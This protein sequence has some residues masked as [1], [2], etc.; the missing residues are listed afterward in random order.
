V[1]DNVVGL[2]GHFVAA[3]LETAGIYRQSH[4]LTD[5]KAAIL[6]Y[7]MYSYTFSLVLAIESLA[8]WGNYRKAFYLMVAPA[9]FYFM[10]ANQTP[11]HKVSHQFGFRQMETVQD[12]EVI[13]VKEAGDPARIG[14]VANVSTF[15]YYYD[16][17]ISSLVQRLSAF[18]IDTA[19]QQDLIRVARE[20]IYRKVLSSKADDNETIQLIGYSMFGPCAEQVA[21][22]KELGTP[23]LAQAKAGTPEEQER[24]L[25][26][27]RWEHFQSMPVPIAEEM[28]M[29]FQQLD[30]LPTAKFPPATTVPATGPVT[31]SQMWVY[32]RKACI[33]LADTLLKPTP[34][35][36][37]EH[38]E[39]K[40]KEIYDDVKKKMIPPG[41]H[42]APGDLTKA[43]EIL[44]AYLLKNTVA[45]TTVSQLA[46]QFGSRQPW[47]E[48][49]FTRAFGN[50][51]SA[52]ALGDRVK[53]VAFAM[54]LPYIQGVLLFLLS[55]AFPFFCIFL[56][57]PSKATQF[58]V[59]MSLWLWV[60]SWDLG[61]AL[62]QFLRGVFWELMPYAADNREAGRFYEMDWNDPMAIMNAVYVTDPTAHLNTFY[63]IVAM[64]TV[65]IPMVS[66]HLCL[67]AT[68]LYNALKGSIDQYAGKF[69]LDKTIKERRRFANKVEQEIP[70][71]FAAA[72]ARGIITAGNEP[73]GGRTNRGVIRKAAGGGAYA[74]HL[75]E[76]AREAGFAAN[77]SDGM[78]DMIG[79]LSMY[80]GRRMATQAGG[81]HNSRGIVDAMVN[82]NRED[83]EVDYAH[84]QGST[85]NPL[86][87][88]YSVNKATDI[89]K[90]ADPGHYGSDADAGGD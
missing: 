73:G 11:V 83:Y 63:N 51:G 74:R 25:K 22:G 89:G 44:A 90:P 32:T 35:E 15:F 87:S 33:R 53:I 48:K 2:A 52:E 64:L 23:R 41:E 37:K 59:W 8:L 7:A 82:R 69:S 85:L 20:S 88:P 12:R 56:L 18:L 86:G 36:L 40:W 17:L 70:Y 19:N 50:Y 1:D 72:R 77:Y 14:S 38:P 27:G 21:L 3:A 54:N 61:L 76:A 9:I 75:N 43:P 65:A 78:T 29:Y 67:G 58:F 16:R 42:A 4:V 39:L 46:T 79:E 62:V 31:C 24:I 81:Y 5:F 45:N 30:A 28:R 10:I 66:A 80:T 6:T 84:K 71:G 47:P 60:K 13:A 49:T 55:A 68:N 57:I 34:A 26:R